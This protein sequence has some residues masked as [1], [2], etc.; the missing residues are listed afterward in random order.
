V[1]KRESDASLVMSISSQE[2]SIISGASSVLTAVTRMY[3]MQLSGCDY[4]R[5]FHNSRTVDC[6]GRER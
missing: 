6:G 4:E 3:P 5:V 2:N 1:N